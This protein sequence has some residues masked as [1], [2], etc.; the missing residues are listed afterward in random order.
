VERECHLLELCRYLVLNPVR[1]GLAPTAG[2]WRWSSYNATAGFSP[3]P[4]WLETRWTREQFGEDERLAIAAFRSFVAEGAGATASPWES[5]K[6]QLFLGSERF[7]ERCREAGREREAGA[8]VPRAQRAIL[9]PTLEAVT[10]E[11]CREFALDR[12]TLATRGAGEARR[13]FA[14]LA[15][16]S[17][18][19][20][21]GEVAGALAVT[22]WAVSKLEKAGEKLRQ[23]DAGFRRRVSA[24]QDRLEERDPGG[25][26][27]L[28][29]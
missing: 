19:L 24:M 10:A 15:R 2:D 18:G 9:R 21:L 22:D 23:E 3:S 26:R 17:A 4:D 7:L 28:Q 8:E 11:V 29:P 25:G 27:V 16:N 12:E 1:A 6:D 20:A 5:V 13:A 14:W